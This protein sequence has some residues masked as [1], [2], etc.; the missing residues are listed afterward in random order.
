MLGRYVAGGNPLAASNHLLQKQQRYYELQRLHVYEGN[1]KNSISGIQACVFGPSS[2]LG[3]TIGGMLTGMGSQC[4]YPHRNIATIWNTYVKDLKPI[5]DLG[6]K[7]FVKLTDFTNE[8]EVAVPMR[9]A[10]TVISCIGSKLYTREEKDFV[11]SNIKVPMAI[12]KAV[13]ANPRVK[14]FVMISQ[15]GADPNS[16]SRRL[17]TKWIG[18][19]EVKQIYPDVTILRPTCMLN[20]MHQNPTIVGKWGMMNKMFNRMNFVIDGMDAKV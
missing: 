8:K 1:V 6:Y 12:A 20:L 7:S 10:N 3:V 19:Q 14:R 13:K 4:I 11:E 5:A 17:R 9:E 15:A 16:H 18:E 2:T